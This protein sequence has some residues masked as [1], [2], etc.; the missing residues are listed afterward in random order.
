MH[1]GR[2]YKSKN[3]LMRWVI[4]WAAAL[5]F[6]LAPEPSWARG[7]G[8]C[9]AEG[10]RVLAPEGTVAVEKLKKG[11]AVWSVIDGKLQRA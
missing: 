7:G 2:V 10:T 9:V 3:V 1:R 8:G 5:L 6:F 11:D 4:W